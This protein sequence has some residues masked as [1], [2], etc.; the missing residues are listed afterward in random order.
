MVW[1]DEAQSVPPLLSPRGVLALSLRGREGAALPK[2]NERETGLCCR[3]LPPDPHP[4]V[5]S[6]KGGWGSSEKPHSPG[7]LV[8]PGR[9]GGRGPE[10]DG[11]LP[12]CR[13]ALTLCW[14]F[15][16]QQVLVMWPYLLSFSV[17]ASACGITLREELGSSK[18][19]VTHKVGR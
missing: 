6:G 10:G 11:C 7:E 2:R 18:C 9:G 1:F 8:L 17:T 14:W 16:S 3:L 15:G 5:L 12:A 4:A 19:C 13:C